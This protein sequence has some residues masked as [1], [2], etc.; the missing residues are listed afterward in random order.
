M[1]LLWEPPAFNGRTPVNG[2]YVDV[3]EAS[4]GS[5]CWKA[6]HE[7]ANRTQY[8]K[9]L[10]ME[11]VLMTRVKPQAQLSASPV[12]ISGEGAQ[13]WHCLRLPRPCPKSGWSWTDFRSLGS[14]PGPDSPG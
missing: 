6:V 8:I 12:L 13:T 14:S 1:V 10:G 3:K 2:Y 7:K 5:G 9:V 4:A 11:P